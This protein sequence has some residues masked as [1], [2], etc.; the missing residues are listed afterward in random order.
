MDG[1]G[2]RASIVSRIGV[3]SW[4]PARPASPPA[5][6]RQ[7]RVLLVLAHRLPRSA[8]ATRAGCP[9][10][11]SRSAPS[12]VGRRSEPK[13]RCVPDM[14]PPMGHG[15]SWPARTPRQGARMSA[16]PPLPDASSLREERVP[17]AS[18][19][20][21][22]LAELRE[23][24]GLTVVVQDDPAFP[25]GPGPRHDA[26]SRCPGTTGSRRCRRCWRWWTAARRSAR[27]AGS[28][29]EWESLSGV[30]GLGAAARVAPGLRLALR[31][32]PTCSRAARGASASDRLH[33]RRVE[34]PSARRA[35]GDVRA[36]LERRAP[37]VP[38]DAGARARHARGTSRA[39]DEV[40]PWCRRTSRPARSRRSRSTR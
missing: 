29:G 31:R 13:M 39:P 32:I 33:A 9:C 34:L 10:S 37:V 4:R 30:R 3:E 19:V 5:D 8:P 12:R 7:L 20:V 6:Q 24:A 1:S 27:W 17:T 40:V 28:A 16:P 2:K 23:R 11:G 26:D 22:V 38:A 36:R 21:P 15:V 18:L 14:V 25:P 35:G